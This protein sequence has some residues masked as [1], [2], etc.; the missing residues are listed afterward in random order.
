MQT[1]YL[2]F[3]QTVIFVALYIQNLYV[4][5]NIIR[6]SMTFENLTQHRMKS[7][8]LVQIKCITHPYED[9]THYKTALTML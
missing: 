6:P 5:Q 2:F 9:V 3:N 8:L 4:Y 1:Q 7:S